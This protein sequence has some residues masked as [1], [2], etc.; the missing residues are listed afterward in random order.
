[1]LW[2]Q[3]GQKDSEITFLA[4]NPLKR[5]MQ[6]QAQFEFCRVV[7]TARMVQLNDLLCIK[8]TDSNSV[9]NVWAIQH[10]RIGIRLD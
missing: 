2:I 8:F 6:C 1:M 10:A 4:V 9:A 7:P 5:L 3:E